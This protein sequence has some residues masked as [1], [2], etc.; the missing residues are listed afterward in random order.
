MR[1]LTRDLAAA[2]GLAAAVVVSLVIVRVTAS[3]P[4]PTTTAS[5]RASTVDAQQWSDASV[6]IR[7][8]SSTA[9]SSTGLMTT[10]TQVAAPQQQV[11]V[12]LVLSSGVPVNPGLDRTPRTARAA[13]TPT[14][15]VA[16]TPPPDSPDPQVF[17]DPAAVA[18][19]WLSALCWYDYRG[20]RDDNTRRAA[21]YGDTQMPPGQDPWTLDDHAWAQITT[22]KLSS[23]CTG[24]TATV[25][26]VSHDGV[27]ETMVNLSATQ[28]LS[29]AGTAYQSA[30][31]NFTRILHRD[32][33]GHWGI[34]RQ[35]VAN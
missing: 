10:T 5:P 17:Q 19:A 13:P 1:L 8:S 22:G 25:E 20:G 7:G 31:V 2:A 35:V 9:A 14:V 18:A 21:A 12:T 6:P 27:D 11:L 34:G 3:E 4:E 29:A 28:I 30:P 24:I 16:L 15:T 33:G 26:T 23:A 32:P